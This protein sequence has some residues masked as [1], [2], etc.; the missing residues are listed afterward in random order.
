MKYKKYHS[1]IDSGIDWLGEIPEHWEVKTLKYLIAKIIDNRGRTPIIE[2]TGI[3]M[4]E[5]KHINGTN[6]YNSNNFDLCSCV[7]LLW[8]FSNTIYAK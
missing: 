1:Y 2:D 8:N 3:P 6:T 7:L 4:L 5:A